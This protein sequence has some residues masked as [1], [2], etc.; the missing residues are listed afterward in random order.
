[1]KTPEEIKEGLERCVPYEEDESCA[2]CPYKREGN[3]KETC[4]ERKTA[5]AIAYIERLERERDAAVADL[6]LLANRVGS[7]VYC[8]N[9]RED[10]LCKTKMHAANDRCWEWRDVQEAEE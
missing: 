6:V 4:Y 8:K 2:E 9:F 10:G 5:D 1:M 3:S 7:C